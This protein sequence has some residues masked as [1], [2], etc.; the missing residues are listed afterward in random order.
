MIAVILAAQQRGSSGCLNVHGRLDSHR[1]G[2]N[3][4]GIGCSNARNMAYREAFFIA[5][6]IT[7][8]GCAPDNETLL[9]NTRNGTPV[10]P[11]CRTLAS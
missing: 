8:G 10:T 6:N 4:D 11:C 3:D 7:S 9:L 5:S 1:D 2:E